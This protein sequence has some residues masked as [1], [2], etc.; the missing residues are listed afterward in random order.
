MEIDCKELVGK[1]L[2]EAC[3][4]LFEVTFQALVEKT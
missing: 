4:G 3:P 2:K 1:D